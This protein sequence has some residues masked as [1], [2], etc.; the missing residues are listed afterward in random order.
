MDDDERT[1]R[2]P[3][4]ISLAAAMLRF[5]PPVNAQLLPLFEHRGQIEH[6]PAALIPGF[7]LDGLMTTVLSALVMSFLADRPHLVLERRK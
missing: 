6:Q 5:V 4:S 1:R 3:G 7:E 2:A